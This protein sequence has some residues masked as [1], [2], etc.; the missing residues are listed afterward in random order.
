MLHG[1]AQEPC[2]VGYWRAS[3][4]R[5]SHFKHFFNFSAGQAREGN[6][7][8]SRMGDRTRLR[9]T[10]RDD[11]GSLPP[12]LRVRQSGA[13]PACKAISSMES[14]C[15]PSLRPP[16][17]APHGGADMLIA[18]LRCAAD[19]AARAP[20]RRGRPAPRFCCIKRR[21]RAL[22]RFCRFCGFALALGRAHRAGPTR[23]PHPA[24]V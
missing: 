11:A 12:R 4:R 10:A 22:R 17:P 7:N 23:C 16:L 18:P 5:V 15:T 20:R 3:R 8:E 1:L 24:I 2:C 19:P 13:P 9:E 21:G 6:A 14:S